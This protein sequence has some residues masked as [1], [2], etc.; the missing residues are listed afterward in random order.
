M[1][2]C[3]EALRLYKFDRSAWVDGIE[4]ISDL[5]M[6]FRVA[7]TPPS[8]LSKDDQARWVEVLKTLLQ[9]FN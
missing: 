1:D 6:K 7:K 8:N 2:K 4:L 5:E 9:S 3:I